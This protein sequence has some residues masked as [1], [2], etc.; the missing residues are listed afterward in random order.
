MHFVDLH[1]HILP[2]YDDGARDE[3]DFIAMAE[4]AVRGGTAVMAA[5][6]HYDH[7]SPGL[8]PALIPAAVEGHAR[9]LA[10]RNI[11]LELVPGVEVRINAGLFKAAKDGGPL[12]VLGMGEGGSYM[13]VDLPLF[14][15]P[16]ATPEILFQVQLRG[17]T[18]ILAHPERNR[19]LVDRPAVLRDLV[20]RGIVV[21]VNSGSL[22]GIY[23]K[24]ARRMSRALVAEG[25]A[26][27][28]AS[29]AHSPAGRG[30]DLSGAA[31]MIR[32]LAGEGAARVLL[33]ENPRRVL[34]G[35]ALVAPG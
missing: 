2:G 12:E 21:Q 13:L 5:T 8:D 1:S 9:L 32:R 26:G 7:D 4:A 15:L 19:R 27:L 24:R 30:P 3:A 23:G 16:V 6:P 11:P 14:D 33:E 20:D 35:A 18:P 28:V 22:E 17:F 34:N 25:V 29:D 31:G 10:S